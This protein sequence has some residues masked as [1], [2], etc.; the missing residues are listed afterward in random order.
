MSKLNEM[1]DSRIQKSLELCVKPA[2]MIGV[3]EQMHFILTR[4]LTGCSG[5]KVPNFLLNP[6]LSV[7]PQNEE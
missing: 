2:F 6:S 1:S 3:N 5:L 7:L 4:E